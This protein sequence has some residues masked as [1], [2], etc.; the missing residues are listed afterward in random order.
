ME[1]NKIITLLVCFITLGQVMGQTQYMSRSVYTVYSQNDNFFLRTIPFNDI[2]ENPLGKTIVFNSDSSELYQIQRYFDLGTGRRAVFLSNDG[3]TIAYVISREYKWEGIQYKSI[4]IYKNG[5]LFKE[6]QL[7]DLIDCNPENEDCYLFYDEAI[8]SIKWENGNRRIIYKEGATDFEKALT[9]KATF[10]NNDTLYIFTKTNT[11]VK[12]DLNTTDLNILP[13]INID[14]EWFTQIKTYQTKRQSFKTPRSYGLENLSNGKPFKEELAK[15]LKMVKV[16]EDKKEAE[17]YKGYY[18][19]FQILVDRTGNALLY[20][21]GNRKELPV[22]KVKT[23]IESQKFETKLIPEETDKWLFSSWVM[24]MN[25][26]IKQAKKEKEIFAEREVYKKRIVA[27]SING[28][29]IPKNLE[30]C[31]IELGKTLKTKDVESIKNLEDRSKTIS[32][33][34]NL[35]RWLRNNWG[36]WGG[37]RLQQY[38]LAKGIKHPDSM[39]ATILE[40]YYDWLNEQHDEWRKFE[41]E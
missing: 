32:Y 39:S 8:D 30:E 35:G 23:F 38:L 5:I 1:K 17:K 3:K 9:E 29:Y 26:N 25:K 12:I 16:P 11:L 37:S 28:L 2:L 22:E 10:L 40:F 36:L 14:E 13:I 41:N 4:E 24:F 21:T 33:H 34:D 15:Y 6:Y 18:L 31:F 19:S 20:S 7:T 27:D